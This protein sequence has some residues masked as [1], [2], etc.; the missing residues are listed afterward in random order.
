MPRFLAIKPPRRSPSLTRRVSSACGFAAMFNRDPLGSAFEASLSI[1]VAIGSERCSAASSQIT[2][3]LRFKSA[4]Q[5]VAV[6]RV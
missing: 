2:A 3:R 1:A 5:R 6:K 4:P